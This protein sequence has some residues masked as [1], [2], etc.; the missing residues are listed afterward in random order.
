MQKCTL[1]VEFEISL[2][3]PECKDIMWSCSD[4]EATTNPAEIPQ[5]PSEIIAVFTRLRGH[6]P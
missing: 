1:I 6:S 2:W 3:E 4:S 5:P